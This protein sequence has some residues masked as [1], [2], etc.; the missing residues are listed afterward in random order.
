MKRSDS[1]SKEAPRPHLNERGRDLWE[2]GRTELRAFRVLKREFPNAETRELWIAA[3]ADMGMG[4]P[5]WADRSA[6][7]SV[8]IKND[9]RK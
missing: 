8:S 3:G 5:L 1:R 9:P 7:K 6:P 2:Q 4:W